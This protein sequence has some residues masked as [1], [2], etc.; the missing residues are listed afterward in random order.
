MDKQT[1]DEDWICIGEGDDVISA[2][3]CGAPVSSYSDLLSLHAECESFDLDLPLDGLSAFLRSNGVALIFDQ[4]ACDSTAAFLTQL[5][6]P[7][8]RLE[9]KRWDG[10]QPGGSGIIVRVYVDQ[11]ALTQISSI[12]D[13]AQDYIRSW[14]EASGLTETLSKFEHAKLLE[15]SEKHVEAAAEKANI[16]ARQ[17]AEVEAWEQQL[18]ID[19]MSATQNQNAPPYARLNF[20]VANGVIFFIDSGWWHSLKGDPRNVVLKLETS[21][22]GVVR[23]KVLGTSKGW[24]PYFART[25]VEQ[26]GLGWDDESLTLEA[27][28]IEL[29]SIMI[30]AWEAYKGRHK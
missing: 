13:R 4:L 29:N 21:G 25:A 15:E 27:N 20:L 3:E 26:C 10:D 12:L 28:P 5:L 11:M 17:L 1:K 30:A 16:D 9:Q 19:V 7:Y 23:C 2:D 14:K 18:L 22:T 8:A 24:I 6:G